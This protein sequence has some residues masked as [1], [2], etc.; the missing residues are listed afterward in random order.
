[1][2][3]F[4]YFVFVFPL[5]SLLA[6]A[7]RVIFN[8]IPNA[9]VA[10]VLLSLLVNIFLLKIFALT[11]KRASFET[12]RK[13]EFDDLIR[14]W[15]T[16]YSKAKVFAFTQTL[17]RQNH[18]HPIFALS[19]LGGLAIQIPFFYAMYFVIKNGNALP[20]ADF[21]LINTIDSALKIHVLPI[22]MTAITL[23]N[24]F[25]SSKETS[26]RLQGLIIALL[27]LVLLYE[28]PHALVLYWTTNMAFALIRLLLNK[29]KTPTIQKTPKTK[30]FQKKSPKDF[31]CIFKTANILFVFFGILGFAAFYL[32]S[33]FFEENDAFLLNAGALFT[34]LMF[35]AALYFCLLVWR[36]YAAADSVAL[37]QTIRFAVFNIA[38]LICV[39]TPFNLYQSDITQFHAP[40]T[41][42][43]LS[44]LFGAFLLLSFL[45][46]YVLS[47]AP[48]KTLLFFAF[49]LSVFLSL[50]ILD[51]FVFTGDYGAMDRFVFQLQSAIIPYPFRRFEQKASALL[52]I[53][54][55]MIFVY[56][57]F[58]RLKTLWK[59][60]FFTMVVVAFL[61]MASILNARAS[62]EKNFQEN[63]AQNTT[64]NSAGKPYENELFSYSKTEK[65]IV[66]AV[67]DMFTG[68]HMPYLLD[69]F[70]QLKTQLD[71]F[72]WFE[73]AVSGSNGTI[74]SLPSIIGGDYYNIINQNARRDNRAQSETQAYYNSATAFS[75][76]GFEVGFISPPSV[77][78]AALQ[79]ERGV[80]W[81]DDMRD[82]R[83]FFLKQNAEKILKEMA[84]GT[85]DATALKERG[86]L[87]FKDSYAFDIARFLSFGVFKF[88][89][90]VLRFYIYNDGAWLTNMLSIDRNSVVD[91]IADWFAFTHIGN[92][93]SKKP[94]FKF[95]HSMISH[96][97]YATYAG[98]GQC[99]YLNEESVIKNPDI[100]IAPNTPDVK[101]PTRHGT[102]QHFD[103]EACAL[104]L[105]NDYISWLKKEGIYDNTQIIILSD[106][107]GVDSAH[108]LPRLESRDFGHDILFLLK[109]FNARGQLKNDQ[110]LVANFDAATIFC[111]NLKNGCSKV[112]PN[113]LENYPE[114][115][116]IIHARPGDS[117]FGHE[118]DLWG[119]FRAYEISGNDLANPNNYKDV[120]HEYAT[121]GQYAKK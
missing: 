68:S 10:I 6:S 58:Y 112:Q 9:A 30:P 105:L 60:T 78:S 18:Y 97:P 82:L 24:V 64:A 118:D 3:D 27:F 75:Q 80:F 12:E 74:Y 62:N 54:A 22:L 95:I 29:F 41:V 120:S 110:R 114:N 108:N 20:S 87:V 77:A 53:L 25:L 50:G 46:L 63:I 59:I 85:Y 96:M 31:S 116:T 37:V 101:K 103:T 73:N 71:G 38:F 2:A 43:T 32:G 16:V 42:L 36:K 4:L 61:N 72:I 45:M 88:M 49:A 79:Q 35:I 115:R 51:S 102:Y 1:M 33:Y 56:F 76:S 107:A 15:K 67:L 26:A 111:A 121:L 23:L 57:S 34:F 119:I 113:I 86:E 65:N 55:A 14:S 21:E 5:E 91:S 106:H 90:D 81:L 39:F 28:M 44:A 92:S 52:L 99:Q 109:D 117:Y 11:D 94:T 89:P 100:F 104:F 93:H 13:K 98:G 83:A 84:Q 8:F 70:P 17:Y 47:F 19:A 7:C 48:Q 40:F 69:Y 66:V